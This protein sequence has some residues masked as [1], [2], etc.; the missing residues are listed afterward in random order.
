MAGVHAFKDLYDADC[1][2]EMKLTC[3]VLSCDD[4]QLQE[5]GT[6]FRHDG[7]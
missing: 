2:A 7:E 3:P 6:C 4:E 5:D 1:P